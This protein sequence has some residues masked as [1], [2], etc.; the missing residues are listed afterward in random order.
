METSKVRYGDRVEPVSMTSGT[1]VML[2]ANTFNQRG[3]AADL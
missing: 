3:F 1:A 2:N